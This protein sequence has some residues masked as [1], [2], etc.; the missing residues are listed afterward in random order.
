MSKQ[1]NLEHF[2]FKK[3][4]WNQ[5]KKDKIALICLYLLLLLIIIAVLHHTL[6][7]KDHFM[8]NIKVKH[9]IQPLQ[10]LAELILFLIKK[11]N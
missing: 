1:K 11:V 8:Q 3:Y 5:F 7:M 6:Q 2:S 4:A 10:M 9:Y